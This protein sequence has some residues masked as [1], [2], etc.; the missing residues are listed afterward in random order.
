MKISGWLVSLTT[1][2]VIIYAPNNMFFHEYNRIESSIF[3]SLHRI[4]WSVALSWIIY[5]C[6]TSKGGS[7]LRN[8]S[9]RL[10][11]INVYFSGIIN[12]FLSMAPFQF[13]SKLFYSIYLI[14]PTIQY[15]IIGTLRTSIYYSNR[16]TVILPEITEG[17]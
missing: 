17:L 5:V 15:I 14:F 1:M 13:L 8:Y 10:Y 4:A 6:S 9:F 7:F 16:N 12:C 2:L 11:N 3:L